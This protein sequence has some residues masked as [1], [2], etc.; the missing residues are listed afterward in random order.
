M[1]NITTQIP[2]H[3]GSLAALAETLGSAGVSIEGGGMFVVNG[4]GIANFLVHDTTAARQALEAAGIQTIREQDVII[5]KLNQDQP[6]QLGKLLRRMAQ[7]NVN[8]LTQYSDHNHQL[9]LVVDNP[10]AAQTV[11]DTWMQERAASDKTTPSP[12]PVS[13][14]RSHHYAINVLWTGNKGTGTSTYL[15]YD[16]SHD[17]STPNKPTLTASSDPA[18]RGDKS[19]Y[20]PEEFLVASASA[21]HMLSYLHLCAVNGVVVLAYDDHA[22]GE[23]QE[24]PAGP[25]A[26]VRIDLHP[27]VTISKTS[28]PKRAEA[29]HEEAHKSCFIANSLRIPVSTHPKIA[30]QPEDQ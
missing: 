6:G 23:M 28:D 13:K 2:D 3:P 20:N 16:R 7:A 24:G 10:Q 18:F 4:Q 15:A 29:L 1:K 26:F 17:I 9:V 22:T 19:R 21:C 8:V 5:Q 27:T 12:T 11:S 30:I 25:N 14:P